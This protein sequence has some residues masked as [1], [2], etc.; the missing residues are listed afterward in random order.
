MRQISRREATR[1]GGESRRPPLR[2]RTWVNRRTGEEERVPAGIDPGWDT[3][4]GAEARKAGAQ[5]AL[6]EKRAAANAALRAP[7]PEPG[8]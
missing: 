3:N 5:K 1:R 4:P 7:L 2:R 6:R 8:G